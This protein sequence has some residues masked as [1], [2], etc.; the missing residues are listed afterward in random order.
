MATSGRRARETL[1]FCMRTAK[2]RSKYVVV[3][4]W[5]L[6]WAIH[7]SASSLFPGPHR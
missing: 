3:S 2:R 5:G 7:A 1:P 6:A 4:P